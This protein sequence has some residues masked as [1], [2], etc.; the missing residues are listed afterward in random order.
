MVFA[1]AAS[2]PVRAVTVAALRPCRS[3]SWKWP[4]AFQRNS[5]SKLRETGRKRYRP[6]GARRSRGG[7]TLS[8]DL[9]FA[10]SCVVLFTT[11]ELPLEAAPA[12]AGAVRDLRDDTAALV[13]LG[14]WRAV[15]GEGFSGD[16]A[17]AIIIECS[18]ETAAPAAV[19]D[20]GEVRCACAVMLNGED[21]GKRAR[22]PFSFVIAGRLKPGA[23]DLRVTVTNTLANQY[24]TTHALDGWSPNQ[25]GPYHQR[26]LH[27]EADS[28]PS[29][30][31]GP[32]AIKTRS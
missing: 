17:Y 28:L 3:E 19:L 21:L 31:Y 24:V 27:F 30:S 22:C 18:N 29:G 6:T 25:L 9:P 13:S 8:L 5:R 4:V 26:A 12:Q 32:V 11:G 10:G 1:G 2:R 23:N 7:W 15:V 20:L 16:V 14:D